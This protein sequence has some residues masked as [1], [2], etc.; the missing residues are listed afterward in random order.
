LG[1]NTIFF[2]IFI[3][4]YATTA[5]YVF[6]YKIVL[7]QDVLHFL[8]TG[9]HMWELFFGWHRDY[10]RCVTSWW[11]TTLYGDWKICF[12]DL[13]RRRCLGTPKAFRTD[14]LHSLYHTTFT[15]HSHKSSLANRTQLLF[16]FGHHCFTLFHHITII[17]KLQMF[18]KITNTATVSLRSKVHFTSLN[19]IIFQL[20][21]FTHNKR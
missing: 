21:M 14:H 10:S 18:I 7:K 19:K 12:E 13:L 9:L 6:N 16:H 5:W 15:L 2:Q 11:K 8:F 1:K 20:Q 17:L 3:A 4:K